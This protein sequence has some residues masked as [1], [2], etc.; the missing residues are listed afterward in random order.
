MI[1]NPLSEILIQPEV[2]SKTGLKSL[3]S[4]IESSTTQDLP[5]FN[6]EETNKTKD[7]E[8]KIDKNVRDT[9]EVAQSEEVFNNLEN[10][11]KKTV[12]NF[13]N[14][15]YDCFVDS[16]EI[17]QILSYSVGGHY[18][19]HIDG[20]AVWTSPNGEQIWK[21]CVDRD[22]SII[23][24]LNDDFD[25]GDLVFPDLKIRIRPEPGMMVCFPS[26]HRYLHGVE[27]VT[28]GKRYSIVTW[29]TIRGVPSLN[30]INE[31]L[32]KKYNVDVF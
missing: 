18:L 5:I 16:S 8:W 3:I 17:P 6:P 15:F 27:P 32:S 1:K 10:F 12:K 20:E 31:D 2:L 28:R 19:P 25:G 26:S 30:Q 24:F 9:Q 13:I 23:F 4:H 21:K 29:A 14:P 22:L 11:L 7:I